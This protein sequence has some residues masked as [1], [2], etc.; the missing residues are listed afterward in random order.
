MLSILLPFTQNCIILLL[1][2]TDS[3]CLAEADLKLMI[4]LRQPLG[5]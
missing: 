2:K 3:Y 4:L 1:F 5:L